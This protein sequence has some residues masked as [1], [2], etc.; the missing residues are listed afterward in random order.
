ML[1]AIAAILI[2]FIMLMGGAEFLVRGAVAIASKLK[3]PSLIIGLT[4]VAFGTSVP[5]LVVSVEAAL[6]GN[7]EISVGNVI[8]SNIANILLVLGAS[9]LIYPIVCKRRV[10]LRDFL[11][12][13]FATL[14]FGV[15]VLQKK[16][17]YWNG[18][19]LLTMLV[20]FVLYN[21]KNSKNSSCDEDLPSQLVNKGW[22]TVLAVSVGG[23]TAI[24]F[25]TDFLIDGAVRAA[26]L[27]GVSKEMIGL[28]VIA[29]GTSLPELATSC[30]A[31]YRHQNGIAIGNVIGSNIWNIV[32][33]MGTTAAITTVNVAPQFAAFDLWVM[34]AAAFVLVPM[35]MFK[36]KITRI[37]GGLMLMGYVAY[38]YAQILIV[39]GELLPG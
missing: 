1:S 27:F 18:W 17:V 11:F 14:V 6:G 19:I 5:E 32:C 12:M 10:L 21:Y 31:A 36:D 24:M 15:F 33:I 34:I 26:E 35:L 3:I 23:L 25:G 2:G 8:G 20:L 7:A 4:I 22:L 29:V 13:F 9:A 38:L 28:T 30:V 37:E 39:R 16:L